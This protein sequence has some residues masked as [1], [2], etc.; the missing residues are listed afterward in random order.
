MKVVI[1]IMGLSIMFFYVI[2]IFLQMM[3]FNIRRNELNEC[4]SLAMTSTQIV[5]MENI[6]DEV[7]GTNNC[8]RKIESNDEYI[9]EFANNFY[10]LI[11]TNTDYEIKVYA[12]DY[13]CGLLSIEIEG[14]FRTL[15]GLEKEFTSRKTSI[16]EVMDSGEVSTNGFN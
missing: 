15:S 7:Y 12:I 10:V 4:I 5:M 2:L 9:Q 6:E 13:T 16:I 3:S 14:K 1:R 11:T 8:R